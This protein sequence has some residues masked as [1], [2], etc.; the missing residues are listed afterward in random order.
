MWEGYRDMQSNS[1]I[2][3][4]Y[5][6]IWENGLVSCSYLTCLICKKKLHSNQTTNGTQR[7]N[8]CNIF[9]TPCWIRHD[10]AGMYVTSCFLLPQTTL[11]FFELPEAKLS[12]FHKMPHSTAVGWLIVSAGRLRTMARTWT[13]YFVPN[14]TNEE[15]YKGESM[16]LEQNTTTAWQSWVQKRTTKPWSTARSSS[17][18]DQEMIHLSQHWLFG[19]RSVQNMF[20]RMEEQFG[21]RI[22]VYTWLL[23]KLLKWF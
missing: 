8:Q 23:G 18:M 15:L 3:Q 2:A 4:H 11:R 16:C 10:F 1:S 13:H 9:N 20:S 6:Q 21:T 14:S 12:L 19:V 7:C 22:A 17:Q 5:V